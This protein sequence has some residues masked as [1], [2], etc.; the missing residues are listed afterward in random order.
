MNAENR[1]KVEEA[2]RKAIAYKNM[3]YHC[4]ESVFLAIN[5]T[6]KITDPGMVRIITGFHGG[7]GTHRT[8]PG[9]NLTE[10]LAGIAAGTDD[11]PEEEIP[12][13]QV[14]H[15]CGAVAAGLACIGLLFGRRL[16]TDDLT[17]VDELCY[18]LH[19]RFMKEFGERECHPLR[20][21]WIPVFPEE[22]C[23]PVYKRGA[24]IAVQLILEA[25]DLVPE[26]PRTS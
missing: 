3:G 14:G 10:L 9:V 24:E 19:Q 8:E 21:K 22:T 6:L 18:E 7:G 5:D 2:G 4:S 26:C 12:L 15:L 23:E 11:R 1:K 16:P 17:C 25:P 20:E 13:V